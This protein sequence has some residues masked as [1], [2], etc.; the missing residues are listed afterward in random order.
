[1]SVA[2]AST[3]SP[4]SSQNNTP[5]FR[6]PSISVASSVGQHPTQVCVWLGA[7]VGMGVG[8]ITFL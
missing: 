2:G 3:S 6:S 1:M 8:V 4:A 5:R 7:V